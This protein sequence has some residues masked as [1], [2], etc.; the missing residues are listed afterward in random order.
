MANDSVARTFLVAFLVCFVC[1]LLVSATAAGLQAKKERDA[2]L[3][4]YRDVLA[5]AGLMTKDAEVAAL[6]D[7]KIE[8]RMVKLADGS[9]TDKV[10][11]E[12]FD[13]YRAASD[14]ELGREIPSDKDLADIKRR[15]RFAPIYQVREGDRIT[16][17][18]LPVHGQ[19]LWST[20][21]GYIA[22]EPDLRT[23]AGFGF[24]EHGETPGLGG[25]VDNPKWQAQWEGK[26]A[27]DE[28][29]NPRIEVA[30]GSVDR[31]DPNARYQVD[32]LSGATATSR[33]V[34]NLLRYWLGEDGFGPYLERMRE[35]DLN[36]EGS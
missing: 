26:K 6:W 18:V 20:L 36:D 16:Q 17:V 15:S 22:L 12:S 8:P 34:T 27:L 14:P 19:G 1:S 28:E 25:E 35:E 9:Y 5:V 32:G 21:Y 30:K 24:Y 31:D 33:G 2:Q 10:E 7:E 3:S 11:F 4:Q 13:Q 23:I 29:G